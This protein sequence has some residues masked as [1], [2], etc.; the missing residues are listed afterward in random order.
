MNGRKSEFLFKDKSIPAYF[1]APTGN[2]GMGVVVVSAIFGVTDEIEKICDDLAAAGYPAVAPDMFWRVDPGPLPSTP[3]GYQRG[4]ARA[5]DYD[6]D[7]GLQY[8]DAAIGEI[9]GHPQCNGRVAV[10]GFCF[11]GAF[12]LLGSTRL[13]IDG[14]VC[15]HGTAVE[16]HLDEFRQAGSPLSF[17]YGDADEVAPMSEVNQIITACG[18]LDDAEIFIYPGAQHAYM[19]P[20]RGD[21]YD[22]DAATKSWNRALDFLRRL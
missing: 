15:F 19:F 9:K 18:E 20:S 12:A 6:R 8:V 16:R 22:E 13:G 17:H 2:P 14:G 1:S 21:I 10:M 7:E 11:G 4:I 3:E 5:A